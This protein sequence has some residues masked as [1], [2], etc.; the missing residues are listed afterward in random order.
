MRARSIYLAWA[1][2]LAR[3]GVTEG[4][5]RANLTVVELHMRSKEHKLHRSLGRVE[6]EGAVAMEIEELA[7]ILQVERL[8]VVTRGYGGFA[9]S[10]VVSVSSRGGRWSSCDGSAHQ[11]SC[12]SPAFCP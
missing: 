1:L 8:V 11:T 9:F 7:V 12:T 3:E 5:L 10:V 2:A 4:T 6:G